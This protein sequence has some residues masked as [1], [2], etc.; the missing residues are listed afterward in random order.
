[1]TV[2]N[3]RAKVQLW[4]NGPYWATTNIGAE[5]PEDYG[6]Y[7]WWGDTVGYLRKNDKW[8]EYTCN[9]CHRYGKE[10]CT[11]HTVRESQL[12]KEYIGIKLI[13]TA[14]DYLGFEPLALPKI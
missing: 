6:Y 9:S 10:Y 13:L 8:V 5:K 11:P 12:D 1:M 14:C 4:E 7:F 3:N 2:S